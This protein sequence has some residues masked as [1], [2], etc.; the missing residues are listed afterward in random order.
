VLD[1][2]VLAESMAELEARWPEAA[3][4]LRPRIAAHERR[5]CG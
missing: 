4:G 2:V 5:G 3:A 1:R